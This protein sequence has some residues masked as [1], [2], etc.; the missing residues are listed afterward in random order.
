MIYLFG[1]PAIWW[2]TVP[3]LL[4]AIWAWISRGD[5]RVILPLVAFGAGFL[6]WL[7]A[8]DRQMYFFYAA[9]LVPFTIVL[10]ALALGNLA[11]RGGPVPR[12]QKIAGYPITW[13]QFAVLCYLAVVIGMFFYFSPILYGFVIPD[14]W[15]NQL[16]WLPSWK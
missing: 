12:L 5:R 1:T 7:V 2:L 13:G 3:V 4:W 14:S 10:L 15:Y 11:Q 16:M 6:P 9:P 8:F